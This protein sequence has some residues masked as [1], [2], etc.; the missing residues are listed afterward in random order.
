MEYYGD[1]DVQE[2]SNDFVVSLFVAGI[3]ILTVLTFIF[4]IRWCFKK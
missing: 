1:T 4:L 2:V 3:S